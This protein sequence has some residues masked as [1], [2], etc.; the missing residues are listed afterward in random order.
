[1]LFSKCSRFAFRLSLPGAALLTLLL[2][3][4][5]TSEGAR[6]ESKSSGQ[7]LAV[8]WEAWDAL[9]ANY[10]APD[11]LDRQALV[12][13]AIGR[14]MELGEIDPYPFLTD[15]GRMRGQVPSSVPAGLTDL[16]RA[17]L[18][19][20]QEMPDAESE[21]V[22]RILVQ[23]M[24]DELPGS[25]ST[26]LTPEQLPE[27]KEQLERNLE[28]SYLGIGARVVAQEGRILLFPFS[29]SPA[30][31]AGIQQGDALMAVNGVPVGEATPAEVG[32]QVKGPEGTKVLLQLERYDERDPL[33]L[34]VFRGNIELVSVASQLVQGGI[35]YVRVVQFRLNTGFQVFEALE[36]LKQ[37][38][39]LAL[40]L[41]LRRN[42]GGSAEAAAEVAAQLLPPGSLFRYVEGREAGRTE[43]FI[44]E[45]ENRLDLDDLPMTVLVDGRTIGE[46]EALAAVL[47]ESERA[48]LV[49]V[50]TYG[51]GSDY[52]FVELGDGSALYIPVSRWYTPGGA[53]LG[54]APIQPDLFVEY[55]ET[56]AGV[57]GEMQFNTAYEFLDEQLPLFR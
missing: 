5:C 4:A 21:E 10:V 23:G 9:H 8:V 15:L 36:R 30:E 29:D 54:D 42:P 57:G 32:A 45:Y 43:H 27:A 46:A 7:E 28:G 44:P 50:P 12:G 47:K 22:S 25:S 2:A 17:A 53:W 6:S 49:G 51:E 3:A 18:V 34:E 33:E 26:Y 16:W 35:G 13:G 41:D 55:E 11:T 14:I 40:I 24:M 19:Y 52:G 39:M 48:K 20:Q 38:D 1:M 37:F 31:K 56:S